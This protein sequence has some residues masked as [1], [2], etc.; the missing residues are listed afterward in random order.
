MIQSAQNWTKKRERGLKSFSAKFQKTSNIYPVQRHVATR[1]RQKKKN[2]VAGQQVCEQ[3]LTKETFSLVV[4]DET[5]E[6]HRL[7]NTSEDGTFFEKQTQRIYV[8][9][10]K[11]HTQLF[12]KQDWIIKM[13]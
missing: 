6:D 2:L 5:P 10:G 8:T 1:Q 7:V 11:Y 12:K 13:S 3:C 9:V 4:Q